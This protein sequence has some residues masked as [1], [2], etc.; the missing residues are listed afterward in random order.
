MIHSALIPALIDYYRRLPDV[1]PPGFSRQKISFRVVI[2]PDGR[3]HAIEDGRHTSRKGVPEPITLVM[4]GHDMPPGDI[5]VN[6]AAKK[7]RLLRGDMRYVLGIVRP[8][9]PKPDDPAKAALAFAAFRAFHLQIEAEI[10]EPEFSAVCRFLEQWDPQEASL[11][12]GFDALERCGERSGVF[13]IR[14]QTEFVHE[15]PAVRKWWTSQLDKEESDGSDIGS[16][17]S[18]VSGQIARPAMKHE[19]QIKGV[20]GGQGA[21]PL[22]SFNDEAYKSYGKEKGLNAPIST[23]EAFQYCTALNELLADR[24]HLLQLGNTTVV[25]WSDRAT[26]AESLLAAFFGQAASA[27]TDDAEHAGTSRQVKHFFDAVKRG[28]PH[29]GIE[30]PAAP[31]YV[32]GLSPNAARISMRF[33]LPA[34]VGEFADRL[35]DHVRALEIVGTTDEKPLTIERMLDETV[36]PDKKGF[37]D[38]EK[39]PPQLAGEVARAILTGQRYP[40]SLL[41]Q[42]TGR[43]RTEGFVD[44]DK[45]KDWRYA[46]YSRAAIVKA[47]LVRNYDMEVPVALNQD[48]PDPAYHMGRLFAALEKTQQDALN[49]PNRTIRDAYFASASATPGAVFPRLIRLHQH[50]VEKLEGGRKVNR[51]KLIQEICGHLDRFPAHLPLER[52]GLFHIGYYHQRHDFFTSHKDPSDTTE[53]THEPE[54]DTNA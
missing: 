51:E 34:T 36:P 23:D 12:P 53:N 18:L 21:Q 14:G 49:N 22:V 43:M 3:L 7:V 9:Q 19:P 30:D 35:A 31:F 16:V 11:A 33:W 5:T 41:N 6:S 4:P 38:R 29:A 13:Q 48:H 37:P 10:A 40:S 26:P 1:A 17:Q 24:D 52:Q 50:H 8:K 25:L 46:E 2:E 47:C 27:I 45:R 32:L 20:R 42:V 54:E 39:I 28:V 44:R 15:R